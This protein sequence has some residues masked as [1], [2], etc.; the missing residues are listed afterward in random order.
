MQTRDRQIESHDRRGSMLPAIAVAILVAGGAVALVLDQL[1]LSIAQRELQTASNAAALAAGQEMA[2][3]ELLKLDFDTSVRAD[4]IREVAYNVATSNPAAG[5]KVAV[6][7]EPHQDVRFGRPVMDPLTGQVKFIE[8]DYAPSSVIVNTHRNRQHGNAVSLFMPYLTGQPTGDVSAFAEASISNRISAVRPFEH[9]NVPAWPIAIL[10]SDGGDND[11][12]TTTVELREGPDDWSWNRE[13]KQ[14]SN[15]SDG[16][17]EMILRTGMRE[18]PGNVC[19][20][21]LG[22]ELR[23]YRLRKQFRNGWSWENLQEFGSELSFERGALEINGSA[24]FIGMPFQELKKQI[25]QTRIV[26]LYQRL[27][28]FDPIETHKITVTRFVAIRLLEVRSTGDEIEF[29]VQ[30]TVVTTR[31]AVL[32]ESQFETPI[33]PYIYRLALTQ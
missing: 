29:V 1:W 16:I 23:D 25:G 11:D 15:T 31:T 30:P 19:V 21:D 24:D 12:W 28:A 8:T 17:P 9:S 20:A 4:A 26:L 6:N 32:S 10:E 33:N 5:K 14:L 3:E 22:T 13:K 2:G 27:N 7:T 18:I